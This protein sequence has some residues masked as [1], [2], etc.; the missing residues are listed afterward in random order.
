MALFHHNI[1]PSPSPNLTLC[2]LQVIMA[3]TPHDIHMRSVMR[4]DSQITRDKQSQLEHWHYETWDRIL[5]HIMG[6][7]MRV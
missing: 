4:I 6:I 7:S 5:N 3:S 2:A 1:P